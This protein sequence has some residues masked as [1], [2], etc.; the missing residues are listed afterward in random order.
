[1]Q[2]YLLGFGLSLL[3]LLSLSTTAQE[4]ETAGGDDAS[5][6]RA[7]VTDYIEGYYAG[8]ANRVEQTLHPHY[9]KHVIHGDIQMREKSGLQMISE[10]RKNGPS[11]LPKAEKTEQVQVLD[12]AAEIASAKLTTP[13]WVDYM[14]LAKADG[15]WKILSVVQMIND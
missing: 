3:L 10:V 13:H 9:L 11:E 12:V 4:N 1:M 7:T 6:V 15:K 5:A 2:R 8:D 14:T